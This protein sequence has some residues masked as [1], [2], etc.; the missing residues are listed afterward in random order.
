MQRNPSGKKAFPNDYANSVALLA[1]FRVS[2]DANGNLQYAGANEAGLGTLPAG[3]T[4]TDQ[5]GT[6]ELWN[7]DGTR[8]MIA[9]AAI[10]NNADVYAAAG[11]KVAPTGFIK[12]GKNVGGAATADGD[13]I[14]VIPDQGLG[15]NFN[16][17]AVAASTA[18]TN[19]TAET[20]FSNGTVTFPANSLKAGDVIR[21]R[22]QAIA[23]ATNST[24]TLNLKLYIGATLIAQTGALDV[25]NNDIGMF[26]VELVIRTAGATGTFVAEG[27]AYIGTPGTA[28][29]KP[30]FLGSTT[31]DTTAA[32]AIT[33]SGT[34]SVANA[35][36][37]CRLDV[38]NVSKRAA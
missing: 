3:T 9:N 27:F 38:M 30:V 1:D 13:Q 8:F 28:N 32:Q 29:F 37:S 6:V 36:D 11:G 7:S 23:T 20:V 4:A 15:A 25:V 35:G 2:L 17:V 14:E 5:W 21:V 22:A 26:D 31:I 34:W 33:L 10:A 12:I 18:L 24:D 16:S 19:T